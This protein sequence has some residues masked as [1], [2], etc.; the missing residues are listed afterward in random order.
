MA[1]PAAAGRVFQLRRPPGMTE[2]LAPPITG[3]VPVL[4]APDTGNYRASGP[5]VGASLPAG[6]PV[7][8]RLDG[9]RGRPPHLL[10][11]MRQPSRPAG[12]GAS[13]RAGERLLAAAAS[14]L[15]S[16]GLPGSPVRPARLRPQ[17]A[18]RRPGAQRHRGADPGHRAAAH[19]ADN[20]AIGSSSAAPGG[21]ALRSPMPPSTQQSAEAWSC[22]GP[23]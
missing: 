17:H 18:A 2:C 10:R 22:A 21:R 20:R 4:D 16:G 11:G 12:G 7:Q 5:S 23:S 6:G 13:R 9:D 19:A 14:L 8:S 3:N 15:R 1:A